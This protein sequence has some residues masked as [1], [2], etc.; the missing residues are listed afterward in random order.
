MGGATALT[1]SFHPRRPA[2]VRFWPS[3]SRPASRTRPRKPCA[4]RLLMS[5]IGCSSAAAGTVASF[6]AFCTTAAARRSS[7]WRAWSAKRVAFEKRLP[8]HWPHELAFSAA[9]SAG[10]GSGALASFGSVASC[11]GAGAGAGGGGRVT[12]CAGGSALRLGPGLGVESGLGL[13]I[14]ELCVLGLSALRPDTRRSGV[15]R[16]DRPCGSRGSPCDRRR[17]TSPSRSSSKLCTSS[18]PLVAGRWVGRAAPCPGALGL[19]SNDKS[20]SS[21]STSCFRCAL[22]VEKRRFGGLTAPT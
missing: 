15:P 12:A 1:I 17:C 13:G 10:F 11:A 22:I 6:G 16:T 19:D 14:C 21:S 5:W 9:G 3:D 20:A 18:P 4:K 7:S 2:A 8:P